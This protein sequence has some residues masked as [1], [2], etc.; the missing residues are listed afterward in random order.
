MT[1]LYEVVCK[2][3][4]LGKPY[5][6][7]FHVADPDESA[8]PED[9]RDAFVSNYLPDIAVHQANQLTYQEITVEPLDVGNTTDPIAQ[10]IS[11]SGSAGGDAYT[12]GAHAWVRLNTADNFFRPG[13]KMIG[14]LTEAQLTLGEMDAANALNIT[15]AFDELDTALTGIS[16][17]LAVLR[18]SLSTPGFPSF[19]EVTSWVVTRVSTNNR[20]IGPSPT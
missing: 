11:I 14:G 13:G 15:D 20:R 7:I 12:R 16:C 8:L 17:Y 6:N 1:Y 4:L 2:G 9:I 19:S 10:Q 3:T 5:A 18:P